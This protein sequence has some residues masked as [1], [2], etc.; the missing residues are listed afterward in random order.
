M[1][2]LI[3]S[4][5]IDLSDEMKEYVV[6]K[7]TTTEKYNKKISEIRIEIEQDAKHLKGEVI[8]CEAN[9]LLNG[10]MIRVE[11]TAVSFEKAVN[12]VK[13]HLKLLLAKTR[14]KS[15]DQHRR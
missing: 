1:N 15:I 3:K 10:K 14:K 9:V 12:K 6:E 5:N 13:D 11:K 8:R 2:I 7:F 4:T